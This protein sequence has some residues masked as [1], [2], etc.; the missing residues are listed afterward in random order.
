MER[1]KRRE[2]VMAIAVD[3][4]TRLANPKLHEYSMGNAAISPCPSRHPASL[5]R[6]A[7]AITYPQS[8]AAAVLAVV[9]LLRNR[10]TTTEDDK[11][12]VRCGTDQRPPKTT[13]NGVRTMDDDNFID[14]LWSG[15]GGRAGGDNEGFIGDAPHLR[16]ATKLESLLIFCLAKRSLTIRMVRFFGEGAKEKW[17]AVRLT[18]VR[19]ILETDVSLP[20]QIREEILFA[21]FKPNQGMVTR[22]NLIY[23]MA[24]RRL[25][26]WVQEIHQFIKVNSQKAADKYKDSVRCE[27]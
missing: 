8:L 18:T 5:F 6:R 7:S 10:S 21:Q 12:K 14:D 23:L 9:A 25:C 19:A 16:R 13:E 17:L 20:L 26:S 4:R 24:R 1:D 15:S 11:F 3:L 2:S 22:R 27:N